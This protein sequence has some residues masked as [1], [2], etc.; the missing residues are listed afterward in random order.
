MPEDIS[1]SPQNETT[2]GLKQLVKRIKIR[3][4]HLILG[5]FLSVLFLWLAFR[6]VSW[7]QLRDIL[8]GLNW[9]Y[10]FLS[11]LLSILGTLIR[12]GRWR[13][14]YYPNQR[15]VS[16]PRLAG[17]LFTSQMLNLLIPARVGE[18]ARI[19]LMKSAKPARTLGTIAVE[20][21]LD[22]LTLLA[23]ML[24]L[25]L[26]V[27]PPDWF[28]APKQSF[29]V[30]SLSLLG[31]SLILFLFK[32]PLLSGLSAFLRLQGWSFLVW[33]VGALT[34][35]VLFHA[36]QLSLLFSSAVFYSWSCRWAFP[37]PPFPASWVSFN[38]WSSWRFQPLAC[39]KKSL[40]PTA[41]SCIWSASARTSSLALSLGLE[42]HWTGDG[43]PKTEHNF[44]KLRIHLIRLE[45]VQAKTGDRGPETGDQRKTLTIHTVLSTTPYQLSAIT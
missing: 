21:L 31:A 7:A 22:L 1:F 33:G 25:P 39:Q 9:P 5:V 26:A 30:L 12:A 45:A 28:Q 37:S 23:F 32:K 11:L 40:C 2:G 13:L 35:F 19:A 43:R 8:K 3:P 27:V 14:L 6:G 29:V 15:Q 34:N 42:R 20:K 44:H 4:I 16:A 24:V 36:I 10:V 38:T 41:W 18:L 17:L